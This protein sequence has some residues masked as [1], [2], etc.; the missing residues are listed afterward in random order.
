MQKKNVLLLVENNSVP[1]DRRVM[2]QGK[3]LQKAGFNV[4][5]ISP[6]SKENPKS[7][8]KLEKI[9]VYR[10]PPIFSPGGPLGYVREYLWAFLCTLFI[11]VKIR[12]KAKIHIIHSANPPDIFWALALVFKIFKTKYI[13]DEHD[14][15][16][17]LYL[18]RYKYARKNLVYKML[19]ALERISYKVADAVIV[20]NQSYQKIARQRG[21]LK[22]EKIHIVRNG[23]DTTSFKVGKKNDVWKNGRKY[24]V[25]YLG[26]MA[27]QDG[28][29]YLIRACRYLVFTKKRTDFQFVLAGAGDEFENLKSLSKKLGIE[30]YINFTGRIPDNQV[31]EILSTAD[32]CVDPDPFNPLNNLSTMNKI[33]EYMV[34]RSP[35][36]SFNLK[37]AKFSAGEAALYV[38][39]NSVEALGE[40]IIKIVQDKSLA[41][42]MAEF[43]YNRAVKKLSWQSQE[44]KLLETYKYVLAK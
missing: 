44:R 42:K 12:L 36:V 9:S 7:F 13:F 3:T 17:E 1:F 2:R 30:N 40:G 24:L 10:Y 16:P 35:I 37:E 18:S 34:C 27:V 33:M 31:I 41:N 39:N 26:T 32:V 20:T 11:T 23:P 14:L 5:I 29:D 4:K 6:K 28:V 22:A 43:G 15:S 25:A 21:R 8:E 19:L 38:K